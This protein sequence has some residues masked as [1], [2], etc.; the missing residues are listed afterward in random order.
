M[1][2]AFRGLSNGNNFEELV[3]PKIIFMGLPHRKLIRGGCHMENGFKNNPHGKLFRRV[4]HAENRFE[5]VATRKR[6][7]FLEVCQT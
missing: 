2:V 6:F 3:I 7:K 5:E 1:K 4:F